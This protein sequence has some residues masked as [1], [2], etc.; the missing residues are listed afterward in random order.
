VPKYKKPSIRGS[1]PE[2]PRRKGTSLSKY[3]GNCLQ[4]SGHG[5]KHWI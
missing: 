5:V 4:V 3:T 1:K 2:G